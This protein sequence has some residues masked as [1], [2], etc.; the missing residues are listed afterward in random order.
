MLKRTHAPR[1]LGVT[2]IELMIVIVI[3]A[4]LLALAVPAFMET[5]DRNRLKSVAET[6]L[7]DLELMKLESIKRSAAISLSIR[8]DNPSVGDWCYGMSETATCDCKATTCTIDGV[9]RVVSYTDSKGVI[10]TT[11][12]TA[13]PTP[14]SFSVEQVRGQV[15][16]SE[17]TATL[18]YRVRLTSTRGKELD[19][20]V[21]ALGRFII[22][23]PSGSANMTGYPTCS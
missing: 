4:V 16:L 12:A 17:P 19:I 14:F 15:T 9:S 21:S 18:P 10:I 3:M 8:N 11:P 7:S 6:M 20:E 1:H 22:C 13:S 23:S 2:L 5:I